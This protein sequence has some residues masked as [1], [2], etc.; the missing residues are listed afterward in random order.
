MTVVENSTNSS[1]SASIPPID[2]M[3]PL[4]IAS[5]TVQNITGMVPTKLN[6]HNYITWRSLFLPVMKRFQLLGLIN[7]TDLYPSQFVCDST[8]TRV[9]NLAYDMIQKGDFSMTDYLNSIK[10]ISDK[11]VVAG[12]PVSESDLVTYIMSGLL[13]DYESFVD[14]I[15][16]IT[17]STTSDEL[18]G[19]LLSKEI[20]L[21]KRKNRAT[22]STPFHTYTAQSS[23]NSSHHSGFR[24]NYRGHN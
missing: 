8:G 7:G 17:K 3:N 16:T 23:S 4:P 24:G 9:L 5:V 22:A 10:E 19:L 1:S 13:E 20:S 14:S 18:H 11:L 21:Q 15:E 6:R 12:G 2:T